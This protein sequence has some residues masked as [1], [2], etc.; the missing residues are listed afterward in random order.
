[1]S[2][3]AVRRTEEAGSCGTTCTNRSALAGMFVPG[4]RL[5]ELGQV[6]DPLLEAASGPAGRIEDVR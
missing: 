3:R 1:M 4:Q 6:L 5:D 2:L